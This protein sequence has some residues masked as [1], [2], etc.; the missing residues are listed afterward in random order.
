[1]QLKKEPEEDGKG[2]RLF[3]SAFLLSLSLVLSF[4]SY[5]VGNA[6]KRLSGKKNGNSCL[7]YCVG[8]VT[9]KYALWSA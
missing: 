8:S 5:G 2:D 4:L 1:M 7:S 6:L 9:I 3:S